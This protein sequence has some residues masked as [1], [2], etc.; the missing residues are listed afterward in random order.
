M[1]HLC[2]ELKYSV[3]SMRFVLILVERRFVVI[4][5]WHIRRGHSIIS[6]GLL[7]QKYDGPKVV[8]V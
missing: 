3:I 5:V 7:N 6:Q 2:I 1:R 8:Y 4:E